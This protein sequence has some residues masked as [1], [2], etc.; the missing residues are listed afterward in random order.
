MATI[1]FDLLQLFASADAAAVVKLCLF[2][3]GN[4]LT[5]SAY[6]LHFEG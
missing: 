6:P 1:A 3:L 5:L 4:V 2:S